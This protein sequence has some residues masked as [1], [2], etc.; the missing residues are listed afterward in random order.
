MRKK[1]HKKLK[2]NETNKD[3]VA[4]GKTCKEFLVPS[5]HFNF[6]FLLVRS[7]KVWLHPKGKNTHTKT[8]PYFNK[9]KYFLFV[10]DRDSSGWSNF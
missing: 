2:V 3:G 6:F 9:N 7:L 1:S 10:S 8:C 4:H 5:F